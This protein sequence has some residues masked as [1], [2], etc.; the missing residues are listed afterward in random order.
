MTRSTGGT[1]IAVFVLALG[2]VGLALRSLDSPAPAPRALTGPEVENA[3][4]ADWH[5]PYGAMLPRP[6]LD[7][8]W[9]AIGRMSDEPPARG[10]GAGSW[11]LVGPRTH[12]AAAFSPDQSWWCGRIRDIEVLQGQDHFRIAAASGGIWEV[13]GDTGNP[14]PISDD[15]ES[16]A[17]GSFAS[18]PGNPDDILAG[19]GEPGQ[20]TGAGLWRTLDGGANWQEIPM[21]GSPE[22]FYRLRWNPQNALRVHAATTKGRYLSTDAGWTWAWQSSGIWTDVAFCLSPS[23][24]FMARGD[25][26]AQAG[27]YVSTNAGDTWDPIVHPVLPSTNIGRTSLTVGLSNDPSICEVWASIATA[28]SSK[29]EGVYRS[30]D[31]GATW[32]DVTPLGGS[33]WVAGWYANTIAAD[34]DFVGHCFLGWVWPWMTTDGGASWDKIEDLHGDQQYFTWEGPGTLLANDAGL[35]SNP[36]TIP[37]VPV[38]FPITQFYHL[39]ID[40]GDPEVALGGIQDMG[41]SRTLGVIGDGGVWWWEQGGDGGGTAIHPS[42]SPWYAVNGPQDQPLLFEN[43]RSTDNGAT[44]D[45]TNTGIAASELWTRR[46]RVSRHANGGDK[47]ITHAATHVYRSTNDGDSWTSL[48]GGGF[49]TGVWD[50]MIADETG[51]KL[52]AV[53]LSKVAADDR[54]L[55]YDGAN[56]NDVDPGLP[57]AGRIRKIVP[58]DRYGST[59]ARAYAL[60]TGEDAQ[61]LGQKVFLTTDSGQTWTNITGAGPNA[62]PNVW[63][64]DLIEHP[65]DSNFLYLASEQGAFRTTDGVTNWEKF[66]NGWP[67]ATI[68]RE[69][70]PVYD[71]GPPATLYIYAATFGRSLYRRNV[72]RDVE[73]TS[74]GESLAAA[75]LQLAAG[76][77]PFRGET[78]LSF[79]L[80]RAGD[81]TLD[82]VDVGGRRV[83]RLM[84]GPAAAGAR[85][86]PWDGRDEAGRPVAAGV[87]WARLE[88]GGDV[89]RTRLV[90]IR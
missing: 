4:F 48:S 45:T 74:V 13:D 25:G 88:A 34:P 9:D 27:I 47:L 35:V 60:M 44:W 39:D 85:R 83:R 52:W 71:E 82:I 8:L 61:V 55:F 31:A 63:I 11:E 42:G 32:Q 7:D 5:D 54:G 41:V 38:W 90:L 86:I 76:P 30:T 77:N 67:R 18:S 70:V 20:R 2:T 33:G 57:V 6:V 68:V 56:W 64:S 59:P 50:V 37:F 36:A 58:A 21:N 26:S 10:G 1:A 19:T 12:S 16:L 15:I 43:I 89:D 46:V 69:L 3:F 23:R 28:D 78:A 49:D 53:T 81:V 14:V 51:D 79:R 73:V 72:T 17:F 75:G 87:Y 65:L 40:P 22:G 24:V 29:M 62:L 66:N 84:A 80:E